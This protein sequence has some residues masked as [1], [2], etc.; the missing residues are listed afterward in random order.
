MTSSWLI[1]FMSDRALWEGQ[2]VDLW[3]IPHVISGALIAYV[4]VGLGLD[5]WQ[6]L[7]VSVIIGSAWELFEK[8][9]TLSY[10]EYVSNS[11]A[12]IAFAQVGFILFFY[13]FHGLRPLHG[14][15][16][17]VVLLVLFLASVL[18]GWIS[19]TYYRSV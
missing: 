4:L 15:V 6:G 16:L 14:R 3:T 2:Y 11:F 1:R 8:F 12:D 7:G 13:V 5:F 10:T 9:T 19:Y 18:L 17:A